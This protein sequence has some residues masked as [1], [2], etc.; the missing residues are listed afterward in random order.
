[1]RSSDI[2]Q[3]KSNRGTNI[4]QK[5][6]GA[7]L[8]PQRLKL[9]VYCFSSVVSQRM[10]NK[11]KTSSW[12][13]NRSSVEEQRQRWSQRRKITHKEMITAWA[14][15]CSVVIPDNRRQRDTIFKSGE[16]IATAYQA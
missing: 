14:V 16:R 7:R 3:I 11:R 1:M 5:V 4:H 2:H 13:L 10:K 12:L 15:D 9:P 8:L 6:R